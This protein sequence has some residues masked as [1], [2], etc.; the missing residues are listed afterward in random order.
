[1]RSVLQSREPEP[2]A[3]YSVDESESGEST[4][5]HAFSRTPVTQTTRAGSSGS[6]FSS[7]LC[8]PSKTG[9]GGSRV[10]GLINSCKPNLAAACSPGLHQRDRDRDRDAL[11][12][13][14]ESSGNENESTASDGDGKIFARRDAAKKK[15]LGRRRGERKK[16]STAAVFWA[17]M[18]SQMRRLSNPDVQFAGLI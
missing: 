17:E 15:K 9:G 10:G 8:T 5:S 13:E 16:T 18:E 14:S 2:L 3:S 1:M 11:S 7:F 6:W 4:S 12:A